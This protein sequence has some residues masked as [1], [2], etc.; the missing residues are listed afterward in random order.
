[1]NAP[2]KR[3]I[4]NDRLCEKFFNQIDSFAPILI[5][6]MPNI[7]IYRD[8]MLSFCAYA[9]AAMSV[10]ARVLAIFC[11]HFAV[12]SFHP[13]F[14]FNSIILIVRI[15]K[16]PAIGSGFFRCYC[17]GYRNMSGWLALPNSVGMG[18]DFERC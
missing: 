8:Y 12:A 16:T 7:R 1:M 5:N 3:R 2:T 18:F 11:V 4:Q 10:N 15:S 9:R 14:T 17:A 13:P 6:F